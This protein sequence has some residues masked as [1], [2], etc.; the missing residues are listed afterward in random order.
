MTEVEK[1]EGQKTVVA[2]ITGLLIGGL[3]VWVFS[4]SPENAQA[5]VNNEQNTQNEQQQ[6]TEINNS[7]TKSNADTSV[8]GTG[9]LSIVEQ[10]AGKIVALGETS[11]PAKTGWIAIREYADGMPGNILG[12]ARYNT[13]TGLL[14]TEVELQRETLAGS[15]YQAVFFTDNGDNNFKL[16]DDTIVNGTEITFKI[17]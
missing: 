13:E 5:P 11:Y 10:A 15:S 17:K 6:V 2:F 3:L 4:A 12:A 16:G 7:D 9:S 1:Q 14:P 8:T